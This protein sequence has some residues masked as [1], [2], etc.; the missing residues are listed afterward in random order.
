MGI[1]L[2]EH[3]SIVPMKPASIALDLEVPGEAPWLS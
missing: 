1:K 3:L 2:N